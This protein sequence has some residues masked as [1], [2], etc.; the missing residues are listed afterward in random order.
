M[1]Y[2]RNLAKLQMY[3]GVDSSTEETIKNLAKDLA[4]EGKMYSDGYDKKSAT[5]TTTSSESEISYAV[6][7]LDAVD[8][9]QVDPHNPRH[10]QSLNPNSPEFSSTRW[11]QNLS[12]LM[13]SDPDYYKPYTLDCVWQNL[14]AYG[15]TS[16]VASQA[17]LVNA[18]RK[19]ISSLYRAVKPVTQEKSFTILHEM[20]GCVNSGELLVVLGRPGSGCTSLLK[21]ISNNTD[22]FKVTKDTDISYSGFTPKQIHDHYRGEVIYNG[23]AD[24][25]IPKLTV[26]QTLY[27]VARLKTPR[28]RVKGVHRDTFAKHLTEVTMATYGLSHTRDTM[29]GNDMIRGVSGG[30][31]KRVSLAE[32]TLCGA[33]FQCWD[34][35]TRGLDSAT[36]L[37][38]IQS[39]RTNADVFGASSAVAIYHCS[40]E[41][42]TLFDKVC[43]L[44]KG[45]QLFFGS[46]SDART[47]FE[48]MGYVCPHRQTTADFLTSITSPQERLINPDFIKKGITVPQTPEAMNEYWKQSQAYRN[49]QREIRAKMSKNTDEARR[50]V[51]EAHK[52]QQARAARNSSPFTVSYSQQIRYLLDRDMYRIKNYPSV[53]FASLMGNSAMALILGSMFFKIT[54]KSDTESFY[55]RGAAMFSAVLF[56]AFSCL[57]EVFAL[58]ETRPIIEKQKAYSLYHP[59]ADAFASILSQI[60]LKLSI[61]VCYNLIF[62]FMVHFKREAGAFFFYFLINIVTIFSMSHM[63]R[64]FGSI[65]RSLPEAMFPAAVLLL[66]MAMYTGFAIPRTKMLGWS[67]WIWYINPLAYLFESLMVNEFHDRLFECSTFIPMGDFYA[68]YTGNHRV[69]AARGAQ[70]GQDYV[71]GDDYLSNNYGYKHSHKWRGFGIGVG[72]AVFFLITYLVICEINPSKAQKGEMLIFP[73]HAINKLKKNRKITNGDAEIGPQ[74]IEEGA[75]E[76]SITDMTLLEDSQEMAEEKEPSSGLSKSTGIFHWRNLTYEIETK[77]ET[78]RILDNVDGWVKPGTL[79]ALM[80]VSGAGKTTLLDC[81]ADRLTMGVVTGGIFVDGKARDKAFSRSIGY[82]QQQ[83]LH[84][85][86]ATVRESLRFSAY[87]RQPS[88]VPI[89]EKNAYVEE[90]IRILDMEVFA[91]AIVGTQGEG[92]NVEQRKRLTIGVELAAKPKLLVF[93][94]EPTSGLDSQTAWSICQLMRKLVDNGQAI[95]CTIHQPSAILME[96]FDRLLL[97][98]KGGKTV[99]FGDLGY[100]CRKMIDYFESHGAPRCPADA[101]PAEW[102]LDVIG[103]SSDSHIAENFNEIWRDSV[104]YRQVQN[105]LEAMEQ[106]SSNMVTIVEDSDDGEFAAS[107]W[108]QIFIVSKRL[109][110]QYWRSPQYLWSKFAL[111]IVN[112]LFIGFTFFMTRASL[113]GLQ[114]QTLAIFMF[115]VIFNPLLQQYLPNFVQQ[116]D[117]Y[118]VRERPSRTFSWK[119]FIISQVMVELVWNILAGTV[120]F[121]IYYYTIGFQRN[122]SAAGQLYERGV[123]FWLLCVA[124]FIFIGSMGLLT[125]CVFQALQNAAYV[126]SLMFTMCLSFCGVFTTRKAMPGFWVFMYR[127]SPLTYLLD[128]LLS[129]GVSNVAVTCDENE[130]LTLVPPAGQTCGD[131]LSPYLFVANTGYL[132]DMNA[133]DE[134]HLCE[135]SHT[136]DYLSRVDA[137]YSQRWRNFGIF[138]CF[139]AFNYTAGTILYYIY[140]VPK[141]KLRFKMS[142]KR[143]HSSA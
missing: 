103:A 93:L 1:S 2:N 51:K 141:T 75:S 138:I 16:G 79:T 67:T 127:V 116:R 3:N 111:T 13:S 91:D 92:L 81:L 9:T 83:D 131:Y 65:T 90:V 94:D 74:D 23:E 60:P 35:A 61:A 46:T 62:Y 6:T 42:Y 121:F 27:T 113:Q 5:A 100:G 28:N 122:A 139:I 11:M 29:V 143:K 134:C 53:Y 19:A 41:A 89:E 96:K 17:N 22:G 104:N 38:F 66:A 124:Y 101:N 8:P 34:N 43:V 118:E 107:I 73:Q 15:R 52:A 85:K 108:Y 20:E 7:E 78:K 44:D 64:T 129:A 135:L 106:T 24:V 84:L 110:E 115:A 12:A 86:T 119:A 39:L 10:D 49:L 117:M 40:E 88:S 69:C 48:D 102:M 32:A 82:C 25:H 142:L 31:R 57:L 33:K 112:M 126:A 76:S 56:N 47:Y 140:R 45:Y 30:E 137:N 70:A 114:S 14:G 98:E 136:N 105:E 63:Y 18:P 4:A 58:Y 54:K 133:T 128:A 26:Y 120:A 130:F 99:Y 68:A 97:L 37:D 21:S 71:V 123:L 132:K 36:A 50:V 72:Y 95:L 109:M 59:S 77:K 55:F 87:L 125:I 80:G